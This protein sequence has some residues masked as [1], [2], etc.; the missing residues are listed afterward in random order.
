VQFKEYLA[1]AEYLKGIDAQLPAQEAAAQNGSAAA[2]KG[3][4]PGGGGGD[5]KQVSGLGS[6]Q[7]TKIILPW[8][9][10]SAKQQAS[11][12]MER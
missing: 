6:K 4:R 10:P 11:M 1:R 2:A 7:L 5:G 9:Y 12:P 8:A 3:P